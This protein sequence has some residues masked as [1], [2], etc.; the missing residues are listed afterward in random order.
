M[1]KQEKKMEQIKDFKQKKKK[2]LSYLKRPALIK[3]KLKYTPKGT[4]KKQQKY[5]AIV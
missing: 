3:L 1:N 2:S 5:K 4:L